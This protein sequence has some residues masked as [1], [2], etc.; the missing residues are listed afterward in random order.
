MST[1]PEGNGLVDLSVPSAR[2]TT[3]AAG[4]PV[5]SADLNAIQ[6]QILNV[7]NAANYLAGQVT[8]GRSG[9][10]NNSDS[11]APTQ[12][13]ALMIWVEAQTNG[14]T[15]VVLDNEDGM[16][17]RDRFVEVVGICDIVADVV[18]PGESGDDAVE[19]DL[20]D[21]STSGAAIHGMFYSKAGF[22]PASGTPT[23]AARKPISSG[24]TL[25]VFVR[26]ADGA[27]CMKMS[28]FSADNGRLIA[29]ISC[30]PRQGHT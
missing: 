11:P 18:F 26:D 30:S 4:D 17:W 27:L 29:R 6:D 15:V 19:A 12:F 10:V 28:P 21:L 3:Y 2:V 5:F 25:C 7:G 13:G 23:A 9:S 20:D 14:T 24:N 16:D 22:A 8:P 1:G